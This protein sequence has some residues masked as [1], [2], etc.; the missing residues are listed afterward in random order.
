VYNEKNSKIIYLRVSVGYKGSLKK[1]L[2][3]NFVVRAQ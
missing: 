1:L 2:S 3:D